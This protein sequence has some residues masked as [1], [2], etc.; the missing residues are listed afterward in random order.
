MIAADNEIG[1][2]LE[3]SKPLFWALVPYDLERATRGHDMQVIFNAP[4]ARS[5]DQLNKSAIGNGGFADRSPGPRD[6]A[7]GGY[8]ANCCGHVGYELQ[9]VTALL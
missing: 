8:D 7:L 9:V 3:G 5:V 1:D 2:G 6:Y 4:D